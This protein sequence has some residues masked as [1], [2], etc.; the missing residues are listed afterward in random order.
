M[1][2]LRKIILMSLLGA[3]SLSINAQTNTTKEQDK[4]GQKELSNS[5]FGI[6]AGFT[7]GYG[8][9]YE[10][11]FYDLR[12]QA[13]LSP[14]KD[15]RRERHSLG[16]TLKYTFTD[17]RTTNLFLYQGNHFLY[18]RDLIEGVTF[19]ERLQ[20]NNGVGIGLEVGTNDPV[21]VQFMT[22]YAAYNYFEQIKPT[23]E[24]TLLFRMNKRKLN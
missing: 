3:L 16:T 5:S 2:Q 10:V 8:L 15:T 12:F 9:A 13:T 19:N 22:G 24:M 18:R 20:L 11:R 4:P 14:F 6:A 17:N 23:V 7:I 1:I 21:S